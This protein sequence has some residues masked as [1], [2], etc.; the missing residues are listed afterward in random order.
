MVRYP[1]PSAPPL[2]VAD[3][4]TDSHH[5]SHF[6]SLFHPISLSIHFCLTDHHLHRP[7]KG[8]YSLDGQSWLAVKP[9]GV[10]VLNRDDYIWGQTDQFEWWATLTDWQRCRLTGLSVFAVWWGK[11]VFLCFSKLKFRICSAT[12][13]HNTYLPQI[14]VSYSNYF[15]SLVDADDSL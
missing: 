11:V 10:S 4:P 2:S 12:C 13:I 8:D 15:G 14:S 3:H 9:N 7:L 6:L 5:P 1:F